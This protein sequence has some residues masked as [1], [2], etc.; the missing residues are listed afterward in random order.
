MSNSDFDYLRDPDAI[1]AASFAAIERAADVTGVATDLRDVALRL[2]HAVG[3]PDVI[4]EFTA[5]DGAGEAGQTALRAGVPVLTD[6]RMVADGIIRSGL[7]AQNRVICTLGLGSVTGNAKRAG[8][9]RSAAAVELWAPFLE[10]AVVA[11]G[12]A[13]TALFRLL[14][15][16]AAGWPK[17]ALIIGLPVGYIGAAESKDALIAAAPT[18]FITLR[19]QRG[20]SPVAAAAVNALARNANGNPTP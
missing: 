17:P 10:G 14:E 9:T 3:D 12:N 1:Y 5:S 15:G 2:V 8:T 13:P 20:G 7:P 11:I 19:G 16:L 6:S 4:E 18:P